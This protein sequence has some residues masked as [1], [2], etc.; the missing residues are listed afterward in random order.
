MIPA[1]RVKKSA[2]GK[3][4]SIWSLL[5]TVVRL[6]TPAVVENLIVS[7]V[8]LTDAL[9]LAQLPENSLYLAAISVSSVIYWRLVNLVGCTQ[10]GSSAY[11]SRRWGEERYADAG[12][13]LGH[14]LVVS[15]LL[16]IVA[17]IAMWPVLPYLIGVLSNWDENVVS[18]GVSYLGILLIALPVRLIL[19]TLSGGMRAAGDTRTPL[20]IMIA[21]VLSNIGIT[22]V[23]VFGKLGIPPLG[24]IGAAM[25]TAI[26]YSIAAILGIWLF[27][28]GLRPKL[29]LK[30]AR[31]NENPYYSLTNDPLLRLNLSGIRPWFKEI[32]PSIF[33]VSTS[34]LGEEILVTIGFLTYIGMIGYFGRE[35]LAAHSATIRV[36][37]LSYTAGWGIALATSAMVGQALGAKKVHLAQKLFALNSGVAA[38]IMG[39]MGIFFILYAEWLLSFF[40]LEP[41]VLKIG[42]G[43]M[44]ILGVEQVF[45]G[46]G[47][48]LSGGLRGAGDTFPPFITQIIG[49][50]GMRLGM[51]YILAWPLGMGIYG[52]Y[53]ATLLDWLMRCLIYLYFIRRGGWKTISV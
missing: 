36:E 44:L 22:Y 40:Q 23:L 2:K 10:I 52:L 27:K 37:A 48:T 15:T 5:G 13:A 32:T 45:M 38:T 11:I 33:R 49:V 43:L 8:L 3:P 26:S 20:I 1:K 46:A 14:S 39:I 18:V 19:L 7:A 35:A 29:L 24:V 17:A 42:V 28:K 6:S 12:F 16:G 50:I 41:E 51:G 34:A 4:Q 31:Q 21:L 53:W 47:M 9:M 30:P 25:G